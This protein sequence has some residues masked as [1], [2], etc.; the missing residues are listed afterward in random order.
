M[1]RELLLV[2]L[3]SEIL[4]KIIKAGLRRTRGC[5]W[6][7]RKPFFHSFDSSFSNELRAVNQAE[8]LR[9]YV[10][11]SMVLHLKVFI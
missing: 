11:V 5:S 1:N 3:I 9:K 7:Y 8:V 6:C 10:V 4:I 2:C